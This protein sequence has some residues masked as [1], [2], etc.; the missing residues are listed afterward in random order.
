MNPS[1]T[2]FKEEVFGPVMSITTF[3]TTEEALEL[4]NSSAY[5]LGG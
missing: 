3:K 1:N 2:I 4:A 5:G